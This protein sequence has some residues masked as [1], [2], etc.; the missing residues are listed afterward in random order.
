M[1]IKLTPMPRTPHASRA[2]S[3]PP[4]SGRGRQSGRRFTAFLCPSLPLSV[5]SVL[6]AVSLFFPSVS[7]AQDNT[8]PPGFTALFNGKD[9]A[10]WKGL[11]K[12]PP[13][14]AKLTP[15]QLATEQKTADQRMREHWAAAEG[16]LRYDGKGDNLCTAED[17]ADFELFVDWKIPAKG[18][19]GIYLRGTPQA[20]IWDNPEGSGALYNN[21]KHAR[22]ALINADKPPGEWNTFR[23]LMSGERVTVYTNGLLA[24]DDTVLEN[25][26][27]RDK[28]IYATGAIELQ[29]HGD[30]L[31]FKNIYVRKLAPGAP[32]VRTPEPGQTSLLKRGDRVA[33]VGDSITEQRLYSRYI[34]DYLLMC[35]PEL[36]VRVFQLGWSGERAPG[37]EA[38]LSNDLLPLKPTVVT[39]CYGMND[40]GYKP[41][42]P[43]VGEAYGKS[44]RAIVKAIKGAGAMPVVGAPGAVDFNTFKRPDADAN[45]YNATL[46]ALRDIDRD[47]AREEGAPFAS[48]HDH[49]I[50]AQKK[51]KAALGDAYD[52]CGTDGV[53][54]RQN[55]HLIMA[56]AYLKALGVDGQ[57][58][59][60][61]LDMT[62][63]NTVNTGHKILAS[64]PGAVEIESAKYPF[65]FFGDPAKPDGTRS[66]VPFIPFNDDLNRFTVIVKNLATP[67]ARLDWSGKQKVF[68]KEQLEKGINLIVE[69]DGTPF[70]GPFFETDKLIAQKQEFQ[71]G[72]VKGVISNQRQAR[73]LLPGDQAADD[74]L[75]TIR[76]RLFARDDALHAAVLASLK[77]VK[78]KIVVTPEN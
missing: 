55:G 76:S 36:E 60:I 1:Q 17:F 47:I 74:A 15:E 30:A 48:P 32:P 42:A 9:L 7:L 57:I 20:N 70:D 5:F 71:T 37:F 24:V 66:I 50:I 68:T 56:Y 25:Y 23:I 62:G 75:A 3:F 19:S 12:D 16:E 6:T 8:P 43:A 77:P 41:Y 31:A 29:N 18:D 67:K 69:F 61:T 53:H 39:L 28:P 40:G 13:S 63:A 26:W 73:Q 52:V 78:H 22:T 49:M 44:M 21:Q 72:M 10:N 4:P 35:V 51:A 34:E 54:P 45:V 59:L 46:A 64:S 27:E 2:Q 33:I 11:V 65:C 14:R 38:R 58:G